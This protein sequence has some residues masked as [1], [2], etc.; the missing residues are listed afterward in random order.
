VLAIVLSLAVRDTTRR[1]PTH[2][3]PVLSTALELCVS[4]Q[5]PHP[6]LLSRTTF[7]PS[8]L[9]DREVAH[10][11][12]CEVPQLDQAVIEDF[13]SNNDTAYTLSPRFD[14]G[15]NYRL[16]TKDEG[17]R[18]IE[19]LAITEPRWIKLSRPGFNASNTTAIVYVL[20]AQGGPNW[21]TDFLLFTRS[22]NAWKSSSIVH[23]Y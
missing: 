16:T 13:Y 12:L 9:P 19:E 11:L 15:I 14:S 2:E 7:E 1:V 23:V 17:A 3:Y 8:E 20:W 5:A 22:D 4:R 10:R 18:Q 6:A 21:G